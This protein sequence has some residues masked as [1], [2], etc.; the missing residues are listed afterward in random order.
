MAVV[1]IS[2]YGWARCKFKFTDYLAS[3]LGVWDLDGWSITHALLFLFLGAKLENELELILPFLLGVAWEAFEG[4]AGKLRPSWL[5]GGCETAEYEA[6]YGSWWYARASDI[7]VNSV[8]LVLGFYF[9]S[10]PGM[11]P[12]ATLVLDA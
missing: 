12:Y 2:T 10:D 5:G 7:V 3:P 9:K 6:Q 4:L 1:A 8:F 11:P